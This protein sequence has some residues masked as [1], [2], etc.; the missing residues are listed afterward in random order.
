V[1]VHGVHD[2]NAG[3]R[4]FVPSYEPEARPELSRL[5]FESSP[6]AS[7]DTWRSPVLLIH[8][9]DDRNVA[10]TET[11]ELVEELRKR[12]VHVEQLV[13]PDEVH[14]FLLHRSWIA[15]YRAS[16]DFLMRQLGGDAAAGEGR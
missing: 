12:G 6:M 13:F 14:G 3:I 1:D 4:N 11:V 16:A 15:A 9:D 5:A 2:W 8:G 10:F 7:L